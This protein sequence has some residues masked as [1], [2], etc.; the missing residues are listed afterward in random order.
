MVGSFLNANTK[1]VEY[2]YVRQSY[3]HPGH[4]DAITAKAKIMYLL[5]FRLRPRTLH[6][7]P[8]QNDAAVQLL[9]RYSHYLEIQ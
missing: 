7:N 4:G 5:Q 2:L 6:L 1:R 9:C 8:V 3:L